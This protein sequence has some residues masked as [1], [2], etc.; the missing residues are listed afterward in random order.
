MLFE[1]RRTAQGRRQAI[2]VP[3]H[4][5]WL[6]HWSAYEGVDAFNTK[7]WPIIMLYV[8]YLPRA[9][10]IFLTLDVY[11]FNKMHGSYVAVI[12]VTSKHRYRTVD[13]ISI[14][15]LRETLSSYF[16]VMC[17]SYNRYTRWRTQKL[18]T[19]SNG[20]LWNFALQNARN[21]ISISES[22]NGLSDGCIARH[23]GNYI[24]RHNVQIKS[25]YI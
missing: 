10:L 20:F 8:F 7:Y 16:F 9:G 23:R 11:Q 6:C 13:L 1:T 3:V 12:T 18:A 2:S 17:H 14:K 21:R 19:A 24:C 4:W 5:R 15:K 25:V 22:G